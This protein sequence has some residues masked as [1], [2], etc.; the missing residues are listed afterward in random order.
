MRIRGRKRISKRAILTFESI[1]R[2]WEEYVVVRDSCVEI[3]CGVGRVTRC[4]QSVFSTVYACDI[5]PGMLA[6]VKKNCDPNI[7]KVYQTDGCSLPLRD[8]CISA[9][10]STIVFQHFHSA[11]LGLHILLSCTES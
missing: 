7:V 11:K 5:S 6:L 3:G 8:N 1:L 10:F 2:H 9:A 4:L